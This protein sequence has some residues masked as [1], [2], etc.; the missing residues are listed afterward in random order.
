MKINFMKKTFISTAAILSIFAAGIAT[1]AANAEDNIITSPLTA[2]TYDYA[3]EF[4]TQCLTAINGSINHPSQNFMSTNGSPIKS[5]A[6]GIV[7]KIELPSGDTKPGKIIV[8]HTIEDNTYY[9]VYNNMWDPSKYVEV[10]DIVKSGDTIAEVGSSGIVSTPHLELEIW[11][12]SYGKKGTTINPTTFL[13]KYNVDVKSQSKKVTTV[14]TPTNCSYYTTTKVNLREKADTVSKIITSVPSQGL[15]TGSPKIENETSSYIKVA[16]NG[17]T[18]WVEKKYVSPQYD[19]SQA[20][21]VKLAI[22]T[23]YGTTAESRVASGDSYGVKQAKPEYIAAKKQAM[24]TTSKDP[25]PTLYA[26]CDRFVSTISRLTMDTKLPWGSTVHQQQYLS[27][28]SQWTRYTKKSQAQPGDIFVTKKGGH[29]VIYLGQVNGVESIAHASYLSRVAAI[30]PA[31][32]FNENLVDKLGREYYGFSHVD[33]Q[34]PKVSTTK[35]GSTTANVQYVT[36]GNVNF[37]TG[38]S[39]SNSIIQNLKKGTKITTTG[40]TSGNYYEVKNGSKTGWVST[41]YIKKDTASTSVKTVTKTT[42]TKVNMRSGAGTNNK[43]IATLNKG[44]KVTLTGKNSGNWSQV[45]SGSKTGW[46]SKTYLK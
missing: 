14:K 29:V 19:I 10:G 41:S 20:S 42:T 31:S 37:R 17:K 40:R 44:T 43:V 24:N 22:S 12:N 36:T 9:S 1:S 13:K 16:Y 35:Y 23:S 11:Q 6:D 5:I 3:N 46:V 21:A 27:G 38:P 25:M 45:K 18:G 30:Q 15:I 39:T 32:Y 26:S 33:K 28:S 4:G 2:K 34:A 8:K 7:E